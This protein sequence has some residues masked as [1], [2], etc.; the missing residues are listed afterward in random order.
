VNEE[1]INVYQTIKTK[2]KQLIAFLE[3]QEISK[4][5]F[6]EIRSWDREE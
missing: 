3:K 4:Q 2:P 1:L 5:R 6:L